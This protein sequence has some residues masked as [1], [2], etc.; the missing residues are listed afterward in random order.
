M[1]GQRPAP[2]RLVR[3]G[4]QFEAGKLIELPDKTPDKEADQDVT[5]VAA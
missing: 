3:A 4:A 5:K 2:G 1:R